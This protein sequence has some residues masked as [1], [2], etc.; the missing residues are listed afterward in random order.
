MRPLADALA[1]KGLRL[2]LWIMRG[3]PRSAA[4]ARLPIFGST[5]GSTALD[6]VRYDKS[7]FW[8]TSCYGSNYPS[9]AAD[10]YYKS[11]AYMLKEWD[12]TYVKVWHTHTR[13]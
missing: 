9:A 10:E 6:A 3:V 2:G 12:V 4:T 7:C 13:Q 8:S 5:T 11:V 1:A